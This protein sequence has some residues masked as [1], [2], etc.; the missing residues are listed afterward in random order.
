M[1]DLKGTLKKKNG[2]SSNFNIHQHSYLLNAD[3]KIS[4]QCCY[5]LKKLPFKVFEHVTGL[6]PIIGTMCEEKYKKN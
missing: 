5:H 4:G 3:F 1:K 6:M 2:T